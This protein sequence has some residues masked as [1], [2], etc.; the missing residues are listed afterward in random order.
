[1]LV[2][3]VLTGRKASWLVPESEATLVSLDRID[4]IPFLKRHLHWRIERVFNPFL[5]V[6][7][8]LIVLFLVSRLM[9]WKST[10]MSEYNPRK[11]SISRVFL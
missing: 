3:Y 10:V 4:V 11:P 2:H 9:V 1:M 6:W 8:V 5:I 7:T